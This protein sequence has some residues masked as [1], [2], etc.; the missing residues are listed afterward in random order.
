MWNF[1]LSQYDS[2]WALFIQICLCLVFLLI[3][4]TLRRKI[5]FLRKAFIPSALIGGFLLFL[6]NM[7]AEKIFNFSLVNAR[8]MQIITYHML[9]IGFIAMSLKII[10]KGNEN[11]IKALKVFQNGAITGGT[12]MLQAVVGIIVSLLFVAFGSSLFYDAGVLLPLGFGQGP[13]NALIWDNNFTAAGLFDG[14]GTVGLTIA[15]IGFIVASICGVVYINFYK[16]K[17]E[18]N[19]QEEVIKHTIE[20]YESEDEIEDSESVDKTSIQIAFVFL[21]YLLA[22]GIMWLFAKIS[23][24]TGIELFNNVAWGFN[25]IWGVITA[26][27]VKLIV[28]KLHNKKIMKRRY[29]NNYQMDRISGLSFDLMILAGV[30]A[31]DIDI[32]TKYIGFIIILA[33]VGSIVTFVYVKIMTKLCF[34]DFK[35][36]AFLVNFGTLTGTASNGM[37]LLREVDS[38]YNTP[39]NDVFILSQFPAMLFV[40]PLLILLAFGSKS[41]TNCIISLI[42]FF[43]LFAAYTLFLIISCKKENRN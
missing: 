28:K 14:E 23:E 27:L 30:A 20:D 18:I 17:Q 15:S 43:V 42:I 40:A 13:G 24:W 37:I 5:P 35:H 6:V 1:D 10:N 39:A 4:N 7:L 22:F 9:A 32:V 26:T 12:Y 2:V 3:G 19:H 21:A 41:L 31:I 34:K 38:T 11:K 8:T 33:I 29:I 36:E 25:F 16:R